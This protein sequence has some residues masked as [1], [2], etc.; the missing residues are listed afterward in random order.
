MVLHHETY[1]SLQVRVIDSDEA[2][3][4]SLY[5]VR[6]AWRHKEAVQGTELIGFVAKRDPEEH[7]IARWPAF[8][9]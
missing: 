5:V 2:S 1:D 9:R 3:S 6:E 4:S 7:G 8:A